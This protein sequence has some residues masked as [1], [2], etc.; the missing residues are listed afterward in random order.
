MDINFVS[1]NYTLTPSEE[2]VL[3]KKSNAI[4]KLIKKQKG[5]P[6]LKFD[7]EELPKVDNNGNQYRFEANFM[8]YDKSIYVEKLSSTLR[9]AIDDCF[10]DLKTQ[11]SKESKKHKTKIIKTAFKNKYAFLNK[12]LS[13][14]RK[15]QQPYDNIE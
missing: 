6:V 14:K 15:N 9:N 11:I 7:I 13:K 12:L 3:E 2:K 1:K 4:M 10:S 5:N 8:F